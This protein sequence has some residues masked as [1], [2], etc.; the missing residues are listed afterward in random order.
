M[1]G[2][3]KQ[4][5]EPTLAVSYI[6][7]VKTTMQMGSIV[8]LL[9]TPPGTM[10]ATIGLIMLYAAAALTILVYDVVF[11]CRMGLSLKRGSRGMVKPIPISVMLVDDHEIVRF[12]FRRLIETT[13]DIKVVAEACC[14]EEA[15][16]LALEY[17][18]DIII[19]DINMPGI[20]G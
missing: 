8:F 3:P 4:V 12:G 19:M 7:K 13:K 16:I 20:G 10:I 2:W 5:K 14:G 18:P 9:A 6:G 11:V 15:C 1:N 17:N